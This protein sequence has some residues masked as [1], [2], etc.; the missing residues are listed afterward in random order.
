MTFVEAMSL[1]WQIIDK[2]D[3]TFDIIHCRQLKRRWNWINI[4]SLYANRSNG[5]PLQYL[6]RVRGT[7]WVC[8]ILFWKLSKF[9]FCSLSGLNYF[10]FCSAARIR[11]LIVC[12][13]LARHK[14]LNYGGYLNLV[15][16][17]NK[18][19]HN[20]VRQKIKRKL[21]KIVKGTSMQII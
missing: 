6:N 11:L 16:K 19:Q 2:Y 13:N 15:Q 18:M 1:D 17:G 14:I 21:I 20:T 7:F 8:K 5:Y 4:I 3:I 10:K 12:F 9:N